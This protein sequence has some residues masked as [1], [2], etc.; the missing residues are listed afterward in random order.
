MLIAD[1]TTATEATFSSL[2]RPTNGYIQQN[3]IDITGIT[4][5]MLRN[6]DSFQTIGSQFLDHV[7]QKIHELEEENTCIYQH[8]VFVAH[9]GRAF[10][11]PFLFQHFDRFQV[12]VPDIIYEKAYILDTLQMSRK[13]YRDKRV[14]VPANHRLSTLLSF[15]DNDAVTTGLHRAAADVEATITVLK[16]SLF[17]DN[18]EQFIHKVGKDGKIVDQSQVQPIPAT[19]QDDSDTDLDEPLQDKDV[20]KTTEKQ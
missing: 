15:V 7:I 20:V 2:I 18:R 3:I 9:N 13:L 10:D 8:Y 12:N 16:S 17:W 11:L 6:F 5:S 4:Y 19:P 14:D 1:G